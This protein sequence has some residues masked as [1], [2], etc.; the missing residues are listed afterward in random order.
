MQPSCMNMH[1]KSILA[2]K[3]ASVKQL[4]A[5]STQESDRR[6]REHGRADA[7]GLVAERGKGQ[8]RPALE[9]EPARD[10]RVEYLEQLLARAGKSA[11]EHDQLD[12]EH[13]LHLGEHP[14]QGV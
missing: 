13:R 4:R 5:T 2:H 11:T 7:A 12:A 9:D 3:N 8:P 6:P 10:G 14:G 1:A